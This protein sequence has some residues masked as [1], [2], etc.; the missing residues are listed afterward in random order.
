MTSGVEFAAGSRVELRSPAEIAA[1]LDGS[2]ELDGLPFMPEMTRM[3]GRAYVVAAQADRVCDTI[4]PVSIRRMPDTVFLQAA[5][6]D[7]LEHGGCQAECL[8]F[9]RAAWLQHLPEG[10]APTERAAEAVAELRAKLLPHAQYEV[11]E[12]PR[13]RCQATQMQKASDRVSGKSFI[14]Y[15]DVLRK[16]D[17]SAAQFARVMS[18]AVATEVGARVGVVPAIP[19]GTKGPATSPKTATLDLQPG[20]WVRVR[21]REEIEPTLNN[22]GRNR[23]LWFDREMLRLSGQVFRVHSRVDRLIHEVEGTMI[24]ITSDCVTLEGAE[25]SGQH[26]VG[27]WFCPRAIPPYWREAWLERVEAPAGH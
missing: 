18:R 3:F 15:L 20:D 27:R 23:G 11:D 13:F 6:C 1:T 21:T 2:G 22:K 19:L 8:L 24:E 14:S 17:T 10:A 16:G 12:L 9:V 4:S 5:R 25:C 26:S 7:G